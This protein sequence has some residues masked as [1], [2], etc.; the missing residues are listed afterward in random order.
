MWKMTK[1][2]I[3]SNGIL[4]LTD[5]LGKPLYELKNMDQSLLIKS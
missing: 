3:N 2:T 4:K 1:Y 5:A